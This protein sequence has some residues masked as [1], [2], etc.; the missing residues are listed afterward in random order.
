MPGNKKPRRRHGV[1]TGSDASKLRAW[2][3]AVI[4]GN[5][6]QRKKQARI[7][8]LNG[9]PLGHPLN[10]HKIESTFKPLEQVL[11][12][13]EQGR[14]M[15]ADEEGQVLIYSEQEQEFVPFIPG[16]LHMCYLYDKLAEALTW[17]KQPPGL[18]AFTLK[19]SRDEKVGQQDI[20]DARTTITWMREKV[21]GVTPARWTEL[22][23][24]ACELDRKETAKHQAAEE[25]EV[26]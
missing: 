21:A 26:A 19:L 5:A 14:G 16:M 13:Q 4:Q 24:W 17:S 3:K 6:K 15:L 7:D 10:K 20:D 2:G 25:K 9:L 1:K 23:T 12:D 11:V 22:F 18:R 8:M